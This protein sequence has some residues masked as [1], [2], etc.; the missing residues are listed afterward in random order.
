MGAVKALYYSMLECPALQ[1]REHVC[2]NCVH[3]DYLARFINEH[4]GEREQCDFCGMEPGIPLEELRSVVGAAFSRYFEEPDGSLWDSEES[5]W[6]VKMRP[7][8]DAATEL[9][10]SDLGR[11]WGFP[12]F[13]DWVISQFE[14]DGEVCPANPRGRDSSSEVLEFSW[15][16]FVRQRKHTSRYF[17]DRPAPRE[18]DDFLDPR[19]CLEA[20]GNLCNQVGMLRTDHST[21]FRGRVH[22]AGAPPQGAKSLGTPPSK[23]AAANRMSPP[24]VAMFYGSRQRETA[25]REILPARS[26]TEGIEVTTVEFRPTRPLRVLDLSTPISTPS[27]YD[28]NLDSL[29]R[30]GLFLFLGQLIRELSAPISKDGSQHLEYVPTQIVTEF[31]RWRFRGGGQLDGIVFP[32]AVHK[33]GINCALFVDNSDCLDEGEE[34]RPRYGNENTFGLT[35]L[36][37]SQQTATPLV[38]YELSFPVNRA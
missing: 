24:G 1:D 10:D 37:G 27:I 4:N 25:C 31:F 16:N 21:W 2:A 3:D 22:R 20:I 9:F 13:A 15:R 29:E 17:F 18:D 36:D 12:T 26:V 30:R 7:A 28:P 33:C 34:F 14:E 19:S 32:S 35:M 8:V 23:H 5:R 38:E 11:E 6:A